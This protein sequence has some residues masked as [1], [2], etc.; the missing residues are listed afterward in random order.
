MKC[1][2]SNYDCLNK[3]TIGPREHMITVD[4]VYSGIWLVG[5]VYRLE[6]HIKET[7][8]ATDVEVI[9]RLSSLTSYEHCTHKNSLNKPRISSH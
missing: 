8:G 5:V 9:I 7:Q 6:G 2:A 4:N 1:L 3:V